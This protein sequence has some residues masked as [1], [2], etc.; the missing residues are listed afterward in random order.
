MTM[1]SPFFCGTSIGSICASKKHDLR[2][3]TA[4]WWLST[5]NLFLLF[6]RDAVFFGDQF[7][8]HAM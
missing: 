7:A 1:G 6:A 3:R 5:A 8:G 2:A 4:F